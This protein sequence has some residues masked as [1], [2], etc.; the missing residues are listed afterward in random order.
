MG[1]RQV[2]WSQRGE[3]KKKTVKGREK[4]CK[5]RLNEAE[6]R[7]AD[8]E[9][10]QSRNERYGLKGTLKKKTIEKDASSALANEKKKKFELKSSFSKGKGDEGGG[11]I[12]LPYCP[13][14][15]NGDAKGGGELIG[16][17]HWKRN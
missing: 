11:K 9:R 16:I 17:L 1:A 6:K 2:Y 14:L 4:W 15:E 10:Q 8:Q 13:S 3:S 12:N 7:D 5:D